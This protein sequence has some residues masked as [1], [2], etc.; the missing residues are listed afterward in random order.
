AI[1]FY[2][3]IPIGVIASE[4]NLYAEMDYLED[5]ND[6]DELDLI[7]IFE[8]NNIEFVSNNEEF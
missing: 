6:L 7:N 2:I 8:E 1:L 3:F 4:E 5:S